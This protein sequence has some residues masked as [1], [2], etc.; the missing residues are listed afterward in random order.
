MP[1][2]VMMYDVSQYYK[3]IEDIKKRNKAAS[4]G[5]GEGEFLEHFLQGD[6][7]KPVVTLSLYL[8]SKEW[9]APMTLREMMDLGE[10]MEEVVPDYKPNILI[11]SRMADE[12]IAKYGYGLDKALMLAKA[13]G[14]KAKMK[15]LLKD[16]AFEDVDVM[17]AKFVNTQFN[18]KMEVKENEN[19]N[20]GVNMCKG[21]D[22]LM[23]DEREEGRKE[24]REATKV[25]DFISSIK[26]MVG[27]NTPVEQ[28]RDY[29]RTV[30]PTMADQA[31]M[32]IQAARRSLGL[33]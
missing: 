26:F 15:E 20:G 22:D 6:R 21:F 7:L 23:K 9:D 17:T 31:D 4:R 27:M 33:V 12:E 11:P 16:P 10:G 8:G 18:L 32:Q 5:T 24:A 13:S 30:F 3:Q 25:A 14:D 2:K 29:A 28:I 1:A 19:E